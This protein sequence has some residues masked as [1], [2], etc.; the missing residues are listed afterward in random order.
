MDPTKEKQQRWTQQSSAFVVG[1][2]VLLDTQALSA[3]KTLP[4]NFGALLIIFLWS[5]C[6][7]ILKWPLSSLLRHVERRLTTK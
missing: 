3:L 4:Y 2:N 6:E 5:V 7:D 1:N